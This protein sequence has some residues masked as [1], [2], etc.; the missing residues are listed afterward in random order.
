MLQ[1]TA[2]PRSKLLKYA[3]KN[4]VSPSWMMVKA[5]GHM[6]VPSELLGIFIGV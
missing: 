2:I 5:Q 6:D 3:G 1:S 4:T